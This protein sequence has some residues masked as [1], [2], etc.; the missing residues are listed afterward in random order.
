MTGFLHRLGD[1]NVAPGRSRAQRRQSEK[2][3]SP[4]N[5]RERE[6]S[7]MGKQSITWNGTRSRRF[8]AVVL[9]GASV[10]IVIGSAGLI[11]CGIVA[12]LTR[13][14]WRIRS[15]SVF[16]NYRRI[17]FLQPF[18]NCD[19]GDTA[20]IHW[21]FAMSLVRLG[22]ARREL[23]DEDKPDP[24]PKPPAELSHARRRQRWRGRL[25]GV[26]LWSRRCCYTLVAMLLSRP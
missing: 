26:I 5:G 21:R 14:R 22:I 19:P 9:A 25:S 13:R 15:L 4:L 20:R 2:P 17:V 7:R 12:L 3:S 11:G 16:E 23:Q 6:L 18:W 10:A 24:P 8:A 1:W